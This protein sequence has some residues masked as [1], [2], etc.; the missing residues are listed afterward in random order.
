MLLHAEEL[1]RELETLLATVVVEAWSWAANERVRPPARVGVFF[2][3]LRRTRVLPERL[4]MPVAFDGERCCQPTR[5][6]W[7]W[8]PDV[9][10]AACRAEDFQTRVEVQICRRLEIG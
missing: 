2:Y 6:L 10:Y 9:A 3:Q 7:S 4:R 8:R 5:V 1:P